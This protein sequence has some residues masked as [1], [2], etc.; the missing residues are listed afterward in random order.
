MKYSY[1]NEIREEQAFFNES[2]QLPQHIA[3]IKSK[4]NFWCYMA[5]SH[6]KK[7]NWFLFRKY[8]ILYNIA[9]KTLIRLGDVGL[10][11]FEFSN[12]LKAKCRLHGKIY[13]TVNLEN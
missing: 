6:S 7:E 10:E 12:E 1:Y 2:L 9:N 8:F 5:L 11:A 3:R 4:A 13:N